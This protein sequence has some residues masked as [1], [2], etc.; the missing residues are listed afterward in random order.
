MHSL[1]NEQSECGL[2]LTADLV[3]IRPKENMI[4][5]CRKRPDEFPAHCDTGARISSFRSFNG[6]LAPL[7]SVAEMIKGRLHPK[8]KTKT[9]K[10]NP[11]RRSTPTDST[12]LRASS[13]LSIL[14]RHNTRLFSLSG[15]FFRIQLMNTW[16]DVWIENLLMVEW[17]RISSAFCYRLQSRFRFI[18]FLCFVYFN[19]RVWDLSEIFRLCKIEP[20]RRRDRCPRGMKQFAV[21][22]QKNVKNNN[23]PKTSKASPGCFSK[24]EKFLFV[25]IKIDSRVVWFFFNIALTIS[26]YIIVIFR[27]LI[28]LRTNNVYIKRTHLRWWNHVYEIDR[29]ISWMLRILWVWIY[30]VVYGNVNFSTSN[31]SSRVSQVMTYCFSATRLRPNI[32][33]NN[34]S[35]TAANP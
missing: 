18:A 34:G 8:Y 1:V 6:D 33:C 14:V 29:L 28:F 16:M 25:Q 11:I 24:L 32:I 21:A 7:C 13:F 22:E 19:L 9:K 12:S 4:R 35:D 26:F 15:Y 31:N 23:P 17:E 20:L 5:L 2:H 30:V 3:F 10:E 27:L